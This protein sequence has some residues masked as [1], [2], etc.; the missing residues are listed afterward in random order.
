MK[1]KGVHLSLGGS[2]IDIHG[3]EQYD[4][5]QDVRCHNG[6]SCERANTEHGFHCL[7]RHGHSGKHCQVLGY[8]CYQGDY[9]ASLLSIIYLISS[10]TSAQS[11]PSC[12]VFPQI[13]CE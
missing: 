3:V 12:S 4:S 7:C 13:H 9:T 2:A 11:N 5:C 1:L 8:R 6:G 10:L